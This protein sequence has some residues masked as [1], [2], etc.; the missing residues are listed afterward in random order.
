[1]LGVFSVTTQLEL[2]LVPSFQASFKAN[3][4]FSSNLI[5]IAKSRHANGKSLPKV[6]CFTRLF[7]EGQLCSIQ[8]H[9]CGARPTFSFALKTCPRT[10]LHNQHS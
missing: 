5:A 10:T 3:P 2:A 6:F 4:L 1:M 8:P 7:V 9:C